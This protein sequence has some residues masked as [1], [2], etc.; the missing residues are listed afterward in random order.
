MAFDQIV[1][2]ATNNSYI[3][4][5]MMRSA[6][7]GMGLTGLP[8]GD[9]TYGYWREGAATGANGTCVTMTK[10]TYA[11]H[12]WVEVDGTN[13]PGVYQF[14]VPDAALA[15]GANAV[16]VVLKA[17]GAIDSRLR[18]VLVDADLRDA[19]RLGLT[20]LPAYAA[21]AAGGLPISDAGGLDMDAILA[22]TNELQANQGNWLTATGFSTHSA[23]DAAA[24]VW[25][26]ATSGLTAAGS[27][28]KYLLDH[29]IGI[30][31]TGTHTAQ[32]G[33]S[34]AVVSNGTYGNPALQ[35]L[36]A[37]VP[38]NSELSTALAGADDAVLN[39]ISALND[40]DSAGAQA[41][42]AAALAAYGA[43]TGTNVTEATSPLATSSQAETISQAIDA[44][45]DLSASDV[46]A[47]IDA[48]KGTGWT[49]ETLAAIKA[50]IDAIETGGT[51]LTAEQTAAAVLDAV[52][53]EHNTALSIGQKINAAG[54]AADP[55]LNDPTDYAEGTA[56]YALAAIDDIKTKTDLITTGTAVTLASITAE[57][58][59]FTIYA[60]D[61]Y[62]AADSRNLSWGPTDIW[63]AYDFT[64]AT[65]TLVIWRGDTQYD[66]DAEVAGTTGAKTAS[67]ELAT[68]DT[69]LLAVASTWNYQLHATLDSGS[70][71]T[72]A[73]GKLSIIPAKIPVGEGA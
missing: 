67:A 51:P 15:T 22:D 64:G 43:A 69:A 56:G 8:Y 34:Y 37:D 73:T 59:D 48:I 52:A 31:A 18:I 57:D 41:A 60:G 11:D 25:A 53:S 50:A 28:G 32:S 68:T 40:L 39:A 24:A 19:V 54:S 58:G 14:G 26:I 63:D 61:D 12:G 29:I 17:T 47:I 44:L 6:T 7:T 36:M 30:L 1:K 42:A 20:A 66:I 70:E 65:I 49:Y 4:E 71:L 46:Q 9:V 35:T 27:I 2:K 21:D 45:N 72:L 3:A 23:A 5:V 13:L 33:D 38:T 55:L 10:G 62:D 16:T